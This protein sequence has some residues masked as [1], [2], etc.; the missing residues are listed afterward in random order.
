MR[1]EDARRMLAETAPTEEA[2]P[3]RHRLRRRLLKLAVLFGVYVLSI[4]PMY[5]KWFAAMHGLASPV[6]RAIYLPLEFLARAV[7]FFGQFLDWYV[8]LWL[9]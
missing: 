3:T 1:P 8:S 2:A 6:Y 9:F 5:W 4:G 7:P